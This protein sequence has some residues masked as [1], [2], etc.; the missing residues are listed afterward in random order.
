ML[1]LKRISCQVEINLQ[2]AGFY[3]TWKFNF[4]FVEASIFNFKFRHLDIWLG[5]L[6]IIDTDKYRNMKLLNSYWSL[7]VLRRHCRGDLNFRTFWKSVPPRKYWKYVKL[8]AFYWSSPQFQIWSYCC[9]R[10]IFVQ[11]GLG[12]RGEL[13]KIVTR[14]FCLRI[15]NAFE[16]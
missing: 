3:S 5:N 9:R 13:A 4:K 14:L 6:I 8:D 11:T 2:I 7:I 12:W 1:D 15:N 16:N 10:G